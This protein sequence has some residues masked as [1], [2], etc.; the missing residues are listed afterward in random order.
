MITEEKLRKKVYDTTFQKGMRLYKNGR[1]LSM[2]VE[3]GEDRL[4]IHARVKGS[5]YNI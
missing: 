5:D 4:Y 2:D 1:V 3:E